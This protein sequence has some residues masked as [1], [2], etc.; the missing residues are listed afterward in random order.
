MVH[1]ARD[2]RCCCVLFFLSFFLLLF[3]RHTKL[4]IEIQLI[5]T[6]ELYYLRTSLRI[7][8]GASDSCLLLVRPHRASTLATHILL[9]FAISCARDHIACLCNETKTMS[10][11]RVLRPGGGG[12][13]KGGGSGKDVG[14]G[15]ELSELKQRLQ[16][17]GSRYYE[18]HI[19]CN[20]CCDVLHRRTPCICMH[21]RWAWAWAWVWATP[22]GAELWYSAARETETPYV[23]IPTSTR[24]ASRC[25]PCTRIDGCPP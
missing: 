8:A 25:L 10:N 15:A 14:G 23:Y 7:Q 6:S 18:G 19:G 21:A 4:A 16:Q 2:Y 17:F 24:L 12:G 13:R 9:L 20:S 3:E 1:H 22:D 5:Q 11:L